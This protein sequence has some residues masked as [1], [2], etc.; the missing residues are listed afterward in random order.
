MRRA[1]QLSFLSITVDAQ[2]LNTDG[3]GGTMGQNSPA[4]K[5][6]TFSNEYEA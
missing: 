2:S 4:S 5:T 3:G 1:R 6:K